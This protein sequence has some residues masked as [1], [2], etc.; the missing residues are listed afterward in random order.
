MM[1]VDS[2]E[3]H[4]ATVLA[5]GDDHPGQALAYYASR[6]ETP[7]V[8]GGAGA[9]GLGLT[10]AVTDEQYEA[11]Y[12]PGGAC[13]PT[14]GER[15]AHTRRPGL[16]LVI[17][18]HKSVAELGVVGRAEHMHQIMDAERD[19]TLA[20]LDEL[21]QRVGGRRGAQATRVGAEGLV[22]ATARHATSRAGDPCPHD[23][24]LVANVLR[25]DDDGGWKA[26]DTALWREHL[27]A[28][29]M[30]G[31]MASAAKAVEL[32]YAVVADPGPTGRLGHWAVAG[33][34]D[35]VMDVHSKRAAEIQAEVERTGHDSYQARNVA[36]RATR[37]PKRHTPVGEL[38]GRWTAEIEAT[39]WSVE[40]LRATID[41]AA[42]TWEPPRPWLRDDELRQAVAEALAPDGPLAARKVFSRRDVVVA[43]APSLYGRRASELERVVDATLAHAE[44]VP[45]LRVAGAIERPY[46]TATTIAREQA[47]AAEVDA[48]ARRADAP[49]VSRPDA[50]AALA[51][52]QVA[53]GRPF[54]PGQREAVEA[55][56][57]SGRG[58]DLVVGVAGSGKTTALAAVRDGFERA[59]YQVIGASTSGQA[60]RALGREAGIEESRTLASLR[61]RLERGTTALGPRHVAIL[62]ETAMTDD[63]D[64]LAFLAA[65]REA[66]AKVV[67]VGDHRQL[68]SVGPGGGFEA[69]LRR[70]RDAVHVL[71]E[72]VR[73]R[74]PGERAA[75][76][77]LRAGDVAEAVEW[78]AANGRI[79]AAPDR[80]AALDAAVAGW[81][82]DVGVGAHTAL[83]A[84]RRA[85]VADLNRRGRAEW[86]AMG[87]LSGPELVA[88]GGAAYRAGDRVVTLAPGQRGKSVTSECGTVLA[89]DVRRGELAAVMDDDGRVVHFGG[90]E[91]D[92]DHLAHS[93]AVTVHRSQGSTVERAHVLEDGGGRELAY[94]KMSRAKERSVVYAVA[95]DHEQAVEDLV[96]G[97]SSSRR[98]RW[99][100]DTGIP[101]PELEEAVARTPG[102]DPR[103]AAALRR[104]RLVAER[105]AVVAAAPADWRPRVMR[106][107]DEILDLG[108]RRDDLARGTG[109]YADT[110]AGEAAR[111]LA[112]A[113]RRREWEERMAA[114]PTTSRWRRRSHAREAEAWGGREVEA[115]SRWERLAGP[116]LARLGVEEATLRR[117]DEALR[118]G[119]RIRGDWLEQHPEAAR[120]V[121]RLE[122]EIDRLERVIDPEAATMAQE[123]GRTPWARA[124]ERAHVLEG[125]VLEL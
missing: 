112:A 46:A 39:G 100:I 90:D 29:T 102:L 15:L 124:P 18:A 94:V 32:G 123:V 115:K 82:A 43:V 59:G 34:P 16:E 36:A 58:V 17:S 78:C 51:R 5:R 52:G 119:V 27:H 93:Y 20:Y 7:L 6:G 1:G 30:A 107:L 86:D 21:T 45:L 122:S 73:Q 23:H 47:I 63:A 85:N 84:W 106:N 91:V 2:V 79:V 65:A 22:Y 35:E 24:A 25:M 53:L 114:S 80:E 97:W 12:G 98:L 95:D 70:H 54:T 75:L 103:T 108:R 37:D 28:A 89:V 44:A 57:T 113:T 72:N 56:L 11:I 33:V 110:P 49:A 83:Y 62:D 120:R 74:D 42:R 48:L 66:R 68:S 3:Y 14:T 9:R 101:A 116:E 69:L 64:L 121:A 60:A 81:A 55:A 111:D 77:R 10:G 13:D 76:E 26:A 99:A 4:R 19:A 109:R 96:R 105:D 41:A 50:W 92:G 38:M 125:P 40:D 104:G 117:A 67:L 87:R 71:G 88:P 118:N 61:G 8:W 31:R